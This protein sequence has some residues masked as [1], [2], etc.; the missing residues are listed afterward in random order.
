[1]KILTSGFNVKLKNKIHLSESLVY[2]SQE[3]D[4][5]KDIK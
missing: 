3:F 2:K 4:Q 5:A 1:M